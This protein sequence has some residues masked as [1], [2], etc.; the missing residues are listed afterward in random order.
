MHAHLRHV[1]VLLRQAVDPIRHARIA[2]RA[3]VLELGDHAAPAAGIA[4]DRGDRHRPRRRDDARF[5]HRP[6]QRDEAGRI[7]ARIGDEPR[8]LDRRALRLGHFRKAVGP[9]RC[10]TIRRRGVD[11]AHLR[12]GDQRHRFARRVV[13]Q[14]E[15]H[16]VDAVQELGAGV[17]VLAANWIDRHQRNVAPRGQPLADLQA[18]RSCLAV[19]EHLCRSHGLS[20][21]GPE[22]SGPEA[23][24]RVLIRSRYANG[25]VAE[26]M[27]PV[28][29]LLSR[30]RRPGPACS[31]RRDFGGAGVVEMAA[32]GPVRAID[33][34][35]ASG[36]ELSIV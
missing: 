3:L 6:H 10:R 35:L 29:L 25:R 20:P 12:V 11:H 30:N 19:D 23:W 16:G 7:A 18:R 27:R 9:A 21:N 2:C 14:A 22:S 33:D 36:T 4:G 24:F 15:D 28:H 34:T 13:R 32:R 5:D 17:A 31:D 8:V 26:A 1:L